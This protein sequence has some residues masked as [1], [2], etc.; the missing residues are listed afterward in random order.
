MVSLNTIQFAYAT[1]Q[2]AALNLPTK[3]YFPDV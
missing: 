3:E 2:Q 1:Y